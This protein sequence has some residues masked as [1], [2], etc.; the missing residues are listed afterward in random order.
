MKN[1]VSIE[2]AQKALDSG[3]S[4]YY[5][6]KG[7]GEWQLASQPVIPKK[8]EDILEFKINEFSKDPE[9][10][11]FIAAYKKTGL[12]SQSDVDIVHINED[13]TFF[14]ERTQQAWLM[15]QESKKSLVLIPLDE[16]EEC[17]RMA[18]SHIQSTCTSF[19]EEGSLISSINRIAGSIESGKKIALSSVPKESLQFC[20]DKTQRY[21]QE[22]IAAWGNNPELESTYK[23]HIQALGGGDE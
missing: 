11:A 13:G 18:K 22:Q 3:L 4:V 12:C 10:I 14:H 9:L 16:L 6:T 1:I 21:M 19:D 7:F 23:K 5:R 2:E 17:Y 15:W 20:A 8:L